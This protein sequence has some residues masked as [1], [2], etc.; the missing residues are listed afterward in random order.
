M[1]K[2]I[3]RAAAV[4][5]G[6][7]C[8]C[9]ATMPAPAATH[10]PVYVCRDAGPVVFSDRPCGPTS[11][12]RVLRVHDPGPGKAPSIEPAPPREATLPRT[13]RESQCAQ[14]RR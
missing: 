12:A 9:L 11:E 4:V 14:E 1:L 13:A 5:A 3:L 2:R 10:R 6:L 7:A 8:T